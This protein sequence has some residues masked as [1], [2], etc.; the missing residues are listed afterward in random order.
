MLRR[1]FG[2]SRVQTDEGQS[3]YV[4]T[5]DLE[6]APPPKPGARGGVG[7]PHIAGASGVRTGVPYPKGPPLKPT[8]TS[9][10]G[11]SSANN[12]ILSGGPLF[13]P[14][15][16]PPLPTHGDEARR[17]NTNAKPEFRFPKPKPGFRVNVPPPDSSP[18]PEEKP[19]S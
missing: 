16:L 2:Y 7:S 14:D 1:E 15:D 6:P 17:P 5:E 12:K 9:R 13:G 10:P 11:V 8:G 18:K 3:G 4:A 19:S